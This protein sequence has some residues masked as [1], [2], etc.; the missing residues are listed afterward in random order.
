MPPARRGTRSPAERAGQTLHVEFLQLLARYRAQILEDNGHLHTGLGHGPDRVSH[1]LRVEVLNLLS[2][3]RM[4]NHEDF[5]QLPAFLDLG[6][7]CISN[8]L[9][10]SARLCA[11]SFPGAH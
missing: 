6:P 8:L 2:R 10:L 5:R 3:C 7:D 4:E 9:A 11:C 1:T